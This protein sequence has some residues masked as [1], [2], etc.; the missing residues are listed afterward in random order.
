MIHLPIHQ[1]VILHLNSSLLVKIGLRYIP[2]GTNP[3]MV[4]IE[5]HP[6][7]LIL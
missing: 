6:L 7:K 5:M 1:M 4:D 2:N 3:T